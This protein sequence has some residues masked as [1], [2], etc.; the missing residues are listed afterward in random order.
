MATT[1]RVRVEGL[2]E[3]QAELRKLGDDMTKKI[4][5]SATN[6]GA[7]V[8]RK[9]AKEL[10]P[11]ADE[12]YVVEGTP[13]KRGNLPKQIVVK[14]V[15]PSETPLTSA[16]VVTVRGKKKYGYASRIGSLQEFG[17]V[18][19]SPQPFMRPAFDQEKGFAVAAM[20]KKIADR[21]AKAGKK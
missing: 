2:K 20:K 1:T 16:H 18:K 12:D 11:I 10:A 17:T 4:A 15:K 7:Q 13:V 14:R 19:M 8:I 6:A 21:I 9:R 5:R 3:L